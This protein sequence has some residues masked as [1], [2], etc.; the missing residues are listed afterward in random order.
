MKT[1]DLV[2]WIGSS[3]SPEKNGKVGLVIDKKDNF[4]KI[5]WGDGKINSNIERQMRVINESR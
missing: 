4:F 5:L 2:Q 1:C 3:V